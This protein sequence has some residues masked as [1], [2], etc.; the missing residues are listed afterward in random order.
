MVTRVLD[1]L[2]VVNGHYVVAGSRSA[3][4]I[5]EALDISV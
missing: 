1:L 3:A 2:G 4:P 5:F